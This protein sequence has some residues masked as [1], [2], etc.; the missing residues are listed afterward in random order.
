MRSESASKNVR[1][2][3]SVVSS[4]TS[5][6]AVRCG[7]GAG[8]GASAGGAGDAASVTPAL[9]GAA[10]R[11][12]SASHRRPPLTPALSP[13]G[14]REVASRIKREASDVELLEPRPVALHLERRAEGR[15]HVVDARA[16]ERRVVTEA[17]AVREQVG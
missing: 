10:L 17:R 11:R 9:T 4:M 16:V 14:E 15:L 6:F 1:W 5:P 7:S 3:C 12:S 13:T 2:L 8:A